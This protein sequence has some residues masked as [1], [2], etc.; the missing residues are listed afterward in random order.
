MSFVR[1]L[2]VVGSALAA[3]VTLAGAQEAPRVYTPGNGVSLPVLVTKVNP[4][5]TQQ[6]RDAHIEGTVLLD[7]VVQKD[8]TVGDV[9]V[10]RSLDSVYGLDQQAVDAAKQWQ[11]KPGTKDGEPVAVRV[12]VEINFTLK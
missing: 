11:F 9:G 6:A 5:Y 8:G 10:E 2:L 12:H 7:V 4:Q 3:T 1:R